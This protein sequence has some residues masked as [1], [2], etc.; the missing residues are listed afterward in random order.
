MNGQ[1]IVA[2][3]LIV[4]IVAGIVAIKKMRKMEQKYGIA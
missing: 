3:A 1:G 2:I 4:S